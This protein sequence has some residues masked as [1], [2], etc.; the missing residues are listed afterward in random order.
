MGDGGEG[1]YGWR[2]EFGGRGAGFKGG[3]IAE[4]VGRVLLLG[5]LGY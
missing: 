3:S 5:M 1:W 2:A 4:R